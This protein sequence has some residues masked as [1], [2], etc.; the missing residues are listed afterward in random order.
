MRTLITFFIFFVSFV[1]G[2]PAE[3]QD[4]IFN[5]VPA[6]PETKT[7]DIRCITQD[8]QGFM[9]FG[10]GAGLVRYDGYKTISYKNDPSNSNSLAADRIESIFADSNGLIWIGTYTDGLDILDPATGIF[11]HFLHKQKDPAS[12]SSDTIL[13]IIKDHEG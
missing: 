11:K 12:I 9:W 6:P 8:P 1:F 3:C 2:T 4:I 13:S 5:R 7:W 10:S